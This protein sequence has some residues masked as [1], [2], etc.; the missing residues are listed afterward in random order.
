MSVC[1]SILSKVIPS[2]NTVHFL[3]IPPL[4]PSHLIPLAHSL[5]LYTQPREVPLDV[6]RKGEWESASISLES[7]SHT[8]HPLGLVRPM[9]PNPCG[10]PIT[11]PDG[12]TLHFDAT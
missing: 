10:S 11:L 7:T 3:L 5:S 8:S 4:L 12:S 2:T 6:P 1:L 9:Q